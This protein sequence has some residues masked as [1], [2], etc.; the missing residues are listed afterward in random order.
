MGSNFNLPTEE[1]KAGANP[2]MMPKFTGGMF[3]GLGK[4]STVLENNV[5]SLE[6]SSPNLNGSI[7]SKVDD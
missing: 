1:E 4:P 5:N 6:S 3:K 2:G 7:T